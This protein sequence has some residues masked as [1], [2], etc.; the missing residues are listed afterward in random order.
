MCIKFSFPRR[1][2]KEFVTPENKHLANEDALDFLDKLLRYDHQ[3]R[4]TAAEAMQ[5]PYF[6]PV[7]MAMESEGGGR[8]DGSGA[9]ASSSSTRQ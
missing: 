4:W 7:T 5:H 6:H 1:K 3:E 2:W 9:A 8:T